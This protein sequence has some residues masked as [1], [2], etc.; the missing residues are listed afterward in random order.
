MQYGEGSLPLLTLQDVANVNELL[1][2]QSKAV[3]VFNIFGHA[4][5]L[6]VGMPVDVLETNAVVDQETLRQTGIMGSAIID[7]HTTLIVDIFEIVEAIHPEWAAGKERQTP[8]QNGDACILLAEDSDFFR[9]Q[10]KRFLESS[11]YSV[12]AGEDG[13]TAW[14]LLQKNADKVRLILS[15]IEMP[16]MDGLTLARTVRSDP[17]FDAIPI[18]GLSSLAGDDD[19][20]R[21]LA[22]GMNDYHIKLDKEKLLESV[23]RFFL[24]INVNNS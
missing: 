4:V 16:I 11:G 20:A 8:P 23:K 24:S 21:A 13:Q 9:G 15:D 12:V 19:S 2:E 1:P 22:A 18:I 7:R 14:D 3:V 5:G 6:V 10:V 17:R